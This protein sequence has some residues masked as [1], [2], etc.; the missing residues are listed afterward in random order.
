MRDNQIPAAA[1]APTAAN[2]VWIKLQVE[3]ARNYLGWAT[4][5]GVVAVYQPSASAGKPKSAE[6]FSDTT[7]HELGHKFHQTPRPTKQPSSLKNHPLQYRGHGGSGPHC[8]HGA[9]VSGTA[10]N[11]DDPTEKTPVPQDGDCIMY[12][13]YSSMSSHKFCVVCQSYLQL[14]KMD[15]F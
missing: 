10:T 5:G 6:D 8:R 12:H 4:A 11:W 1:P 13:R 2:P 3:T 15:S 9:T 7:A 14:E